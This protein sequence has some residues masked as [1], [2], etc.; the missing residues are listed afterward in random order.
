MRKGYIVVLILILATLLMINLVPVLSNFNNLNS[1]AT[2]SQ[3]YIEHGIEET[4]SINLVTSI[5]LDYRGFDTL[6]ETIVIFIVVSTITVLA[7]PNLG[8]RNDNICSPIVKQ[9]ISMIIPFLYLLGFYLIAYGHLSPGG[10]FTGG[11]LIAITFILLAVIFGVGY[12]KAEA[13]RELISRSLIENLAALGFVISGMVGIA[14]GYNFLS[15]GQLGLSFGSPGNLVS[16]GLIPIF[17]LMIGI[18][19]GAG[20]SVIFSHL[21][22]EE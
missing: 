12:I 14:A 17:N 19:I 1:L 6:G 7:V 13:R 3:H 8:Y 21:I 2:S 20:M 15:S 4:G 18:K 16:G 22:K 10:G 5:L 11:V 9:S